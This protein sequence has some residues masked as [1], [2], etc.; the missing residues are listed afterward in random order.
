MSRGYLALVLHA[1]LPFV[2]HPA[3]PYFLEEQWFFQAM[4]EIY[5]PLIHVF[6]GLR[7]DDKQRLAEVLARSAQRGYK[8]TCNGARE[9]AMLS[10]GVGALPHATEEPLPR[11][12]GEPDVPGLPRARIR[13]ASC[14]AFPARV[15]KSTRRPATV[16]TGSGRGWWWTA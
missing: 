16:R 1:H 5:I 8:G 14:R 3:H 12:A 6:E 9:R 10:V 4:T 2:R 11:H 7:R 15:W 13:T